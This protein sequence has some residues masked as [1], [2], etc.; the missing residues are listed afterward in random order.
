MSTTA[1]RDDGHRML[2]NPPRE[3]R[4]RMI[5]ALATR[6][7]ED[8]KMISLRAFVLELI[9]SGLKNFGNEYN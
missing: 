3:L 6:Q 8:E 9:E 4:A 5:R 7:M 1:K 2:I